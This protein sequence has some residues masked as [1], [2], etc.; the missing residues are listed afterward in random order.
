MGFTKTQAVEKTE[1]IKKADVPE[2]LEKTYGDNAQAKLAAVRKLD[3]S[4]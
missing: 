2:T 1:V 3:G 4:K